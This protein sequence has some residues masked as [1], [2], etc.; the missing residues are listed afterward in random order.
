MSQPRFVPSLTLTPLARHG[1]LALLGLG[2]FFLFDRLNL[3]VQQ[4]TMDLQLLRSQYSKLVQIANGEDPTVLLERAESMLAQAESE[5]LT[6]GTTGLN[7]AKLQLELVGVLDR[8]VM[9]NA[10]LVLEA[11]T[12]D[13][14]GGLFEIEAA[15]RGQ[16]DLQ[17]LSDCMHQIAQHPTRV[18]V[19]AF[20]WNNAQQV[21]MQLQAVA[22]NNV[23]RAS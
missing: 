9:R 20:R 4:K 7:S 15:L 12:P 3:H 2:I 1:L 21:V 22:R 6:E 18:H 14:E 11:D 5:T 10:T 8:C 23:L 13:V 19:R 17:T 16:A